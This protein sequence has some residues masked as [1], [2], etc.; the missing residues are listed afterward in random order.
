LRFTVRPENWSGEI[1]LRSCLDGTVI[2]YGVPRY[3]ELN[4]KHLTPISVSESEGAMNLEVQTVTSKVR[5]YMQARHALLC[6]GKAA[7]CKRQ[8][9]H[10]VGLIAEQFAFSAREGQEYT[11]EKIVS[12]YTSKD[13]DVTDPQ[14][15]SQSSLSQK[16]GFSDL[17]DAH[18]RAWHGLWDRSDIRVEGDRFAQ[19]ALRLHIY[20]LFCTASPHNRH[21][22]AGMP[23][24]GLHGEAYRGHI[25]WDELFIYPFYNLR[26][27]EIARAL[28]LY[29]YPG[30]HV[31][32]ADC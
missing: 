28:L 25:F 32:L 13:R 14:G 19:Q 10:D 1:K 22:D 3:R 4:S 17:Q 2:N 30:Y 12:L 23:A 8:V 6:D 11:L 20:H 7:K 21:I 15:S 24:R 18:E 26:F 5:I 31:P 16:P 27:P 9:D 29:R